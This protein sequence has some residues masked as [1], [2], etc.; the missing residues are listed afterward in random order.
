LLIPFIFAYGAKWLKLPPLI[1]YI[2]GGLFI[3][4]MFKSVISFDT[5]N[6]FAYFGIILL[7]FT[8]GLEVNF[9]HMMRIKRYIVLGGIFQ[10]VLSGVV[11]FVLSMFFGF[12]FLKS[13]LIGLALLSSSTILVAKI[14]QDRGEENTF[15]GEL[16]IGILMF[17]DIAFIPLLIIFTSITSTSL[18]LIDVTVDIMTGVLKSAV[19]LGI[20]YFVGRQ[21]IPKIF[22][23]V[24]R[25]SREILNLFIILF[26][27]FVTYVSVLLHIPVLIGVFIAGILVA[28]T[29][30]H[31]HIFSQIRPLRDVLA[32]V[33]FVF[34]GLNIN[35]PLVMPHLPQIILFSLM[36]L[37]LK[38]VIIMGVFLFL[39]FH[40]RTAFALS[41]FLFQ[42]DEDAFILMHQAYMN[43]VVSYEDYLFVISSVF[44]TL[45]L[46]PILIT[47][48]DKIYRVIRIFIKKRV[49]FL[50]QYI[51]RHLDAD[52]GY[53]NELDIKNHVV[54]CGYG[55]I[56]SQ[57]GQALMTANIP[58]IAIDYNFQV[59]ER[60]KKQGINII[61]G[62]PTDIDILDYAQVDRASV[63]VTALAGHVSQ[64]AIVLNT[65]K[66]NPKALI[67]SRVHKRE[68]GIRLKDLGV[69]VVIQPEF[70]ASMSI[71]RK[72]LIAFHTPPDAIGLNIKR[73]KLEQGIY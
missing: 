53:L 26:I 45:I 59:V 65:Q 62:D 17:Q 8:V 38:A 22:N 3:G 41:L 36:V 43:K 54:I 49:V 18:S 24:T 13:F 33:F 1:G 40:T 73:L 10:I 9:S 52:A 71:V 19:I 25:Q 67:I 47:H 51:N 30:E 20:L 16:A 72:L 11:I 55:R 68:D 5:V 50:D 58:F 46:T 69:H 27:F 31:H 6:S 42:I 28:Q 15:V 56:G 4:N 34:I 2:F 63:V 35:L 7:L 60:L 29:S 32:V 12:S 48:K 39:R 14:I 70:E 57:I 64:E 37:T 23:L 21:F 61:Y 66:L 44:L